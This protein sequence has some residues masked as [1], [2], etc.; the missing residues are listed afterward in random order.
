PTTANGV[1]TCDGTA[2]GFM[3]DPGFRRTSGGCVPG[4]NVDPPRPIAPL[5]FSRV[6]SLRPTFRWELGAG[7]DGAL[8]QV[9]QDRECT[10]VLATQEAT[11]GATSL[12]LDSELVL[13]AS[14]S[15]RLWFRLFGRS[16]DATGA[17]PSTTWS[18]VLPARDAEQS[19][20][21][22]TVYDFN[23]DGHADLAVGSEGDRVQLF[24][25]TSTGLVS[26]PTALTQAAGSEFGVS[27]AAAGDVDGD[28]YGDLVLGAPG[29]RRAYVYRG[30]AAGVSTSP[31]T[32]VGASGSDFGRAVAGAGDV[33]GDGYADGLVG[34]PDAGEALLFFGGPTMDSVVDV[35]F[36]AGP[37]SG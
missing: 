27:V 1:A 5:N 19:T 16:D 29:I 28:G 34:A 32:L 4:P 20:S 9:C 17:S 26:V 11:G 24:T 14:G 31:I 18:F 7:S 12:R 30:S 22:G 21:F 36:S 2:C 33:N 6:T 25:G 13:P 23:A 37:V 35:S 10:I 15:R 3:C 8:V